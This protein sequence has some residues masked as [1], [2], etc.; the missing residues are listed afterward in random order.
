[1]Y[2]VYVGFWLHLLIYFMDLESEVTLF[3]SWIVD[4]IT[5]YH[6]NETFLFDIMPFDFF[7]NYVKKLMHLAILQW[8]P[9]DPQFSFFSL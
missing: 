3:N 7:I 2:T 5:V 6:P 8:E 4:I 9:R 1:M